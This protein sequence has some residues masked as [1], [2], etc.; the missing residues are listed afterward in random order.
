VSVS[1]QTASPFA[2]SGLAER[3]GA[4]HFN[5]GLQG[6]RGIA[7]LLVLFN[8]A[9]VPGFAG[10]YVG[11]DVFFVI[12]GYL[13]GGLLLRELTTR[14]RIDLWG[15]Y[16]RRVRRLLPAFAVV[17]AAVLCLIPRLYAPFEHGELLSSARASALYA[18]NLWF[19]SRATDYF[20]GHTEANP[21]LHL[22]SLAVEEQFYLFWPLLMLAASRLMPGDARRATLRLVVV[23]GLL[24]LVACVVVSDQKLPYA[25]FLTPMRIWEFAAGMVLAAKPASLPRFGPRA[26]SMLGVLALL[27]IAG[28]TAF[29]DRRT[30][31]PGYLALLPTLG[32]MGL[33]VVV[34]HG[35]RTW[36]GK[37]LRNRHLCWVGDCSYS[38]YLWHWPLL[39]FASLVSPLHGVALTVLMVGL[40]LLLGWLSYRWVER[41]FKQ[42][43]L[44]AWP[45]QRV[46]LGGLGLCMA[47]ALVAHALGR[48]ELA[49]G[50]ARYKKA[51]EWS[52]AAQSGCLS[53]YDVTDQPT[54]EFGATTAP[55]ATVVLFGDSHAMQ[56]FAGLEAVAVK[57]S[58]R[59]IALTKAAC[60]SVDV[61]VDFYVKRTE[62]KPCNVWREKMFE[63]I[64]VIKPDLVLLASSTG[65][66]I[67]PQR[68]S[69]GL[70]STVRRLQSTGASVAFLRDT[71]FPGF[72]VPTCL[73][74]AEWRGLAPN[75]LCTYPQVDREIWSSEMVE[76][77]AAALRG[78][79][80]TFLDF[81]SAICSQAA[82]PTERK[83]TIMFRD[84]NHITTDFAFEL[85]TDLEGPLQQLLAKRS[86]SARTD[87]V[88]PVSTSD[89]PPVTVLS[90]WR[91]SVAPMMDR[92]DSAAFMRVYGA[93][94]AR[95]VQSP[96]PPQ[97]HLK[98]RSPIW[99]SSALSAACVG[100]PGCLGKDAET[101]ATASW[102]HDS[103]LRR[104]HRV[105]KTRSIRSSRNSRLTIDDGRVDL[106][107]AACI[108]MPK[109]DPFR[110]TGGYASCTPRPSGSLRVKHVDVN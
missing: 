39:I 105:G 54:C 69:E 45:P 48:V 2:A 21:L 67:L 101:S 38:V 79:G 93:S 33:L 4:S 1:A 82:C 72:D 3:S 27:G 76:A 23:A 86:P 24:S 62:Y 16:A 104:A 51:A 29:F 36:V 110:G 74:R 13:I 7:I 64:Q 26:I 35:D 109:F 49:A 97:Q 15:F 12:S 52:A 94:C 55:V 42:G 98:R 95:Y 60:P 30:P 44:N 25:F 61:T 20:G 92:C 102:C 88:P 11:V 57:N 71:P 68:W 59:L 50:Q 5:Q 84:R 73:A 43:L 19:A 77:E 81:S 14:G 99:S 106:R 85:R 6:M 58:W 47:M 9:A 40:S 46:V 90:P 83:G 34:E 89:N 103:A 80:A 108:Q 91:L 28:S 66:N 10:G 75:S 17:L 70:L 63:R 53:L 56:W 87:R 41:P 100:R 96:T 32:S 107:E 22:W 65:Y 8:H 31:F 78:S 18:A 37:L